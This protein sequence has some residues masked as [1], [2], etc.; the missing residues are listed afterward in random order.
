VADNAARRF[1]RGYLAAVYGR[2]TIDEIPASTPQLREGLRRQHDRV[3]PAQRARHPHVARLVLT[4][5][6]AEA[7]RGLATVDD[8]DLAPY[9]LPFTI[10]RDR[11]GHWRVTS[12]GD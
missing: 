10:A 11:A 6:G 7:L 9:P 8:G 2:G 5:A 4:A 3:P 1:L 12:V